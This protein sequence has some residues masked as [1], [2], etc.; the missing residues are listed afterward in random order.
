MTPPTP[1]RAGRL[2]RPAVALAVLTAASALLAAGGARAA[3][4]PLV[5]VALGDSTAAGQGGGPGGGYPPRLARRLEGAGLAVKLVNLGVPGA[6]VADLRRDQLPR[7]LDASPGLVTVGIGINDLVQGR[8]LRDFAR[9]LEVVADFLRHTRAVVVIS[10]LPDLGDSPSAN[11]A[12]AALTRRLDQYN[13]AIERVA[14][15]HGFLVADAFGET[16][17]TVKRLGAGAV[18]AADGFH[19]S[20]AGYDAWTDALW[21]PVERALGARLQGR[22]PPAP[23][24]AGR[25]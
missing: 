2:V 12:P 3:P 15:R 22:R 6:T 14:E 24:A 13:A 19:P 8:P 7:A 20:A 25:P 1:V 23:A 16:R 11:G 17:R 10:S 4:A 21:R 18:F 5:Y 9:D